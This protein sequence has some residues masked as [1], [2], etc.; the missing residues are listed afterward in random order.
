VAINP[1]TASGQVDG[2]M[3]M[4]LGYA[5]SEELVLDGDGRIVNAQIGPYW[6][7]RADD[8]PPSEVFLVQTLEPSGPFGAKAVGEIPVDGVA[9]AV[10]N[11]ILDA[12]GVALDTLPF[13]PERVWQALEAR[14]ADGDATREL[15][16]VAHRR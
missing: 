5:L 3:L 8:A 12:A 7:F 13:T 6:L 11:A 10:R 4:A 16:E 9:P 15:A 14:E 2:G 1:L